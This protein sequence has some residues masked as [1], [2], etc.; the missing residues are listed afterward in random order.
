M[1]FQLYTSGLL[2][3]QFENKFNVYKKVCI[4][5]MELL[6]FFTFYI[7]DIEQ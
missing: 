5:K 6:K 1:K 2:K 4:R 3:L 7:L